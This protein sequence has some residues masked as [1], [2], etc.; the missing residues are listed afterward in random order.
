MNGRTSRS[1]NSDASVNVRR[2]P[3]AL[4]SGPHP[5][6][7]DR[8]AHDFLKLVGRVSGTPDTH[9]SPNQ[10]Q[11]VRFRYWEYQNRAQCATSARLPGMARGRLRV[12][13]GAA[14]GV[15]KTHAMLEE[16]IRRAGR[17]ADVLVGILDDT[18]RN[19]TSALAAGLPH[20]PTL[21]GHDGG[22]ELDVTALRQRHPKVVLVDN[23]AHRVDE[24]HGRWDRCRGTADRWH[25]RDHDGQHLQPR[26]DERH[27]RHGHGHGLRRD[28]SRF[29]PARG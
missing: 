18:G 4:T 3:H 24:H 17:G 11:R 21:V 2:P 9:T 6:A 1:A 14:P 25:R 23:L 16:G 5:S 7:P 10:A 20:A 22:A 13:L 15:G 12:Y 27:R 26:V 8:R 29:G 28:R 19:G